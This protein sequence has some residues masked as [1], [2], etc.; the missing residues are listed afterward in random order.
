M[1][2][3]TSY[4]ESIFADYLVSALG[5]VAGSLG[6]TAGSPQ[7]QEAVADALL[8]LGSASI[9]SVT[10]PFQIRGLRA[11]GRLAIWRAVVQAVAGNYAFSGDG[12]TFQRDQVQKQ[13]L[14]A[15]ELAETESLAWSPTYAVG[16]VSV[17][18]P[19]D[20]YVVI[21]DTERVP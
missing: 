6:W 21:P 10:T 11:L 5:S 20:P 19:S 15:L 4:T 12:A 9:A 2:P 14:Q 17:K 16:I 8:D 3:P 18:R 1:P 13:A 7:V